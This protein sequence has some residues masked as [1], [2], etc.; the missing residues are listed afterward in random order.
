MKLLIE[1]Y[2]VVSFLFNFIHIIYYVS[3]AIMNLLMFF[4]PPIVLIKQYITGVICYLNTYLQ[5]VCYQQCFNQNNSAS[6]QSQ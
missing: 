3:I 1:D 4:G 6:Q 5:T 2:F